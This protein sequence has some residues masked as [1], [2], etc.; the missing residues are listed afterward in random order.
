MFDSGD[1]KHSYA[2]NCLEVLVTMSNSS[3]YLQSGNSWSL[4]QWLMGFKHLPM[5]SSD[6]EKLHYRNGV[7]SRTM[8]VSL[9]SFNIL[10]SVTIIHSNCL[11]ICEKRGLLVTWLK[12]HA[13]ENSANSWKVYCAGS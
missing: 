6:G 5:S 9:D 1:G 13:S 7:A 12:S 8:C 2:I 4:I 3:Q 11:L 10:S